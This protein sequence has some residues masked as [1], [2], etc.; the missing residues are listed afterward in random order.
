MRMRMASIDKEKI[1]TVTQATI[2]RQ[3]LGFKKWKLLK[4]DNYLIFLNYNK[5]Q[6]LLLIFHVYLRLGNEIKGLFEQANSCHGLS[7][8]WFLGLVEYRYSLILFMW[9]LE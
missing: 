8:Y 2:C 5:G 9:T 6:G 4:N 7:L 1:K 3:S